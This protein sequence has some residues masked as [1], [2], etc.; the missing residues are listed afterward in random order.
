MRIA[1]ILAGAM[2]SGSLL[3][4]GAASEGAQT[5]YLQAHSLLGLTYSRTDQTDL[6]LEEFERALEIAEA[7]GPRGEESVLATDDPRTPGPPRPAAPHTGIR[8]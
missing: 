4:D 8:R 1:I 2:P 3:A 7:D 5:S 6:A